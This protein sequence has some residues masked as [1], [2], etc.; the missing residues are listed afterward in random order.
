MYF[1]HQTLHE[2]TTILEEYKHETIAKIETWKQVKI[3]KTKLGEEF[4]NLG[5]A[6][7]W[8]KLGSYYPVEDTHHPYLT[9]RHNYKYGTDHLQAFYYVDELPEDKR[10]RKVIYKDG[11]SR[12]TSP[13]TAEELRQAIADHIK[14]LEEHLK[15]L[16]KQLAMAECMF[17][18]YRKAIEEAEK[19]IEAL[20]KT[21]RS[22]DIYPT[23]LYHLIKSVR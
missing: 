11:W 7:E 23:S 18:E 12:P 10:D 2:I 15:D 20:D 8:A 13:M 16:D 3:K 17:T 22:K 21:I 5:Q 9:I 19:H 14:G 6:L 4:K 1:K